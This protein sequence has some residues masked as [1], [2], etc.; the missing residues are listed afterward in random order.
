VEEYIRPRLSRALV[1]R[2]SFGHLFCHLYD[3]CSLGFS[4][5]SRFSRLP[6]DARATKKDIQDAVMLWHLS[7]SINALVSFH[8]ASRVFSLVHVSSSLFYFPRSAKVAL[9][10]PR[11]DAQISKIL[12]RLITRTR[13][14]P[15]HR[16][17]IPIGMK[18]R[19]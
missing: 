4:H 12:V 9:L 10:S 5:F 16:S 1:G 8:I 3:L 6:D 19:G 17:F 7:L 11:I 14:I 15:G 2:C 18:L 13:P